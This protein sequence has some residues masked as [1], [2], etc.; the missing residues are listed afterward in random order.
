MKYLKLSMILITF[1]I[2]CKENATTESGGSEQ[3]YRKL[4]GFTLEVLRQIMNT[5]G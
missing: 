3:F 4:H 1:I 5:C 2:S